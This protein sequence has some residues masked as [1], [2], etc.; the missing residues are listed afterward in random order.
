MRS[1]YRFRD[2][3]AMRVKMARVVRTRGLF[4]KWR[5]EFDATYNES[6]IDFETVLDSMEYAGQFVGIC[7][8]RPK[9]GK[10]VPKVWALD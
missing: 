3:R 6:L 1:D 5:I 8:S 9:H 10:F 4:N 2:T 7:D